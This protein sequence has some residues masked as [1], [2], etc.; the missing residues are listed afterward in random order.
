MWNVWKSPPFKTPPS[1]KSRLIKQTNQA[2]FTLLEVMIAVAILALTL[3]PLLYTHR[4]SLGFFSESKNITV[5]T[6]LA[7][8]KIT[9]LELAGLSQLNPGE[10]KFEEEEFGYF[11]WTVN[12]ATPPFLPPTISSELIKE[13]H[14]KISWPGNRLKGEDFIE[15]VTYMIKIQ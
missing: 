8:R 6:L 7:Q 3:V 14:V 11:K 5:A 10:G 4:R 1:K 9:E 15:M 12:V 2:G 13:V